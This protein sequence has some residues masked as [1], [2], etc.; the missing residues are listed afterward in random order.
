[1]FPAA[2]VQQLMFGA[3]AERRVA[4]GSQ[5]HPSDAERDGVRDEASTIWTVS[6]SECRGSNGERGDVPVDDAALTKGDRN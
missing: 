3:S 5:N 4:S 2:S 1:M 6:A